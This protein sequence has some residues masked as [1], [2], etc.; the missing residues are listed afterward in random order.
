VTCFF[1]AQING[2]QLTAPK[3]TAPICPS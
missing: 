1:L 2:G 3:G